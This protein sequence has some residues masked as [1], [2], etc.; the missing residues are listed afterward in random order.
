MND[1]DQPESATSLSEWVLGVL[2]ALLV[3][4][5]LTVL[6]H[7]AVTWRGPAQLTARVTDVQQT[8]AGYVTSVV[9]E[10]TG[11]RTAQ[12]AQVSGRV[13]RNDTLVDSAGATV[14]YVPPNSRRQVVLV[15]TADP[16]QDDV[17]LRVGIAGFTPM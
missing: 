10:N 17:D 1:D 13:M 14:A 15:F 5:L 2:G 7:Q 3:A 6:V 9:V 4:A 12:N 8:S 11:S 16:E